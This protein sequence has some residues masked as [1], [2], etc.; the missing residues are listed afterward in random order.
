MNPSSSPTL[1]WFGVGALGTGVR[2]AWEE[3]VFETAGV[4]EQIIKSGTECTC[5]LLR[6]DDVMQ[7]NSNR[8]NS[9]MPSGG[10][11]GMQ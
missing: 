4:K 5:M 7:S 1:I 10:M 11:G 3:D 8:K 2:D 9:T 6:I